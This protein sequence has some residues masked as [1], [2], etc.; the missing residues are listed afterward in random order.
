LQYFLPTCDRKNKL[1]IGKMC[2]GRPAQTIEP[3]RVR[4]SATAKA[5]RPQ[6]SAAVFCADSDETELQTGGTIDGP[7]AVGPAAVGS[8]VRT[9]TGEQTQN[10]EQAAEPTRF[11]YAAEASAA[12]RE[13]RNMPVTPPPA[14]APSVVLP[15]ASEIDSGRGAAPPVGRLEEN[16]DAR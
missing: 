3:A 4:E 6:P 7:Q 1:S 12:C 13:G 10:E 14:P 16:S 5:L 11:A 8:C 2:K 9:E 15:C